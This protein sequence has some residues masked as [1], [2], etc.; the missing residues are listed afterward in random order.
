MIKLLEFYKEQGQWFLDLPEEI[1]TQG[2]CLMVGGTP[3]LFEL[4]TATQE[5]KD[6]V[7]LEVSEEPT[8]NFD[9]VLYLMGTG[10]N[11]EDLK[12]WGHEIVGSG[13]FYEI[14]FIGDNP[15]FPVELLGY[16]IWICPTTVKVFGHYPQEIYIKHVI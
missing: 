7:R 9:L 2:E 8:K 1:A 4:F 16:Q 14:L 5:I 12:E 13:G 15:L 11:E 3:E 10:V 6:W